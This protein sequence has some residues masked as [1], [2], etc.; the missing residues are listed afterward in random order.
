MTQ[1]H[2][3]CFRESATWSSGYTQPRVRDSLGAAGLWSS[4]PA[5]QVQTCRYWR[6]KSMVSSDTFVG[7]ERYWINR[8]TFLPMLNG[9][10]AW[11]HSKLGR[12]RT[13]RVA[14]E[15]SCI[16][17]VSFWSRAIWQYV[18]LLRLFNRKRRRQSNPF[19]VMQWWKCSASK[20]IR[21]MI[22]CIFEKSHEPFYRRIKA[23]F[24]CKRSNLSQND[25]SSIFLILR[26]L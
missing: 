24:S 25:S 7:F 26:R 9:K 21:V 18:W 20:G 6:Q 22:S 12:Q 15:I 2:S 10:A 8:E 16:V 3:W 17:Y 13:N 1:F 14:T 4:K 19:L 5:N 23:N 11:T